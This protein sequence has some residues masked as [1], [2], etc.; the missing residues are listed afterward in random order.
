MEFDSPPSH[1]NIEREIKNNL[2]SYNIV[3]DSEVGSIRTSLAVL[4]LS[5]NNMERELLDMK[6]SMVNKDQFQPI[7]VIVYGMVATA[8]SAVLA[9]LL[10]LLINSS[11][12]QKRADIIPPDSRNSIT[13]VKK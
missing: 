4:R 5:V 8:L 11:P 13:M 2:D 10:A 6:R 1:G 7:K 9:G 12:L 3:N